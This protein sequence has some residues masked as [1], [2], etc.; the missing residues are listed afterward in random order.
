MTELD[1]EYISEDDIDK[2]LMCAICLQPFVNPIVHDCGNTF[3]KTCLSGLSS[4]PLCIAKIET[5]GLHPAS[6]VLKSMVER[7]KVKC[8]RCSQ[9]FIR[10]N[11][12]KHLET[13]PIPC[14]FGCSLMIDPQTQNSHKNICPKIK[15]SCCGSSVG[16]VWTGERSEA[17]AHEATCSLAIQRPLLLRIEKLEKLVENLMLQNDMQRNEDICRPKHSLVAMNTR[18]IL[19]SAYSVGN[20]RAVMCD[21]CGMNI[22]GVA[23]H[24]T[25]C[26]TYD[27]C[28]SCFR[29]KK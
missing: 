1:F 12:F 18:D 2:G 21:Q 4:C 24:C 17:S 8:K 19:Q 28:T 16:C 25:N 7:L 3:C 22:D 9:D 27:N 6:L 5:T 13:C 29:N 14:P 15:I 20:W 26:D 11:I 10:E 23:Y